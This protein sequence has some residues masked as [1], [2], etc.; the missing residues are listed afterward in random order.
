MPYW[1]NFDLA[2]PE[3]ASWELK[4]LIEALSYHFEWTNIQYSQFDLDV[5]DTIVDVVTLE[6]D[7]WHKQPRHLLHIEFPMVRHFEISAHQH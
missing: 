7:F 4:I 2:L 1:V 5:Q 6:P 3:T